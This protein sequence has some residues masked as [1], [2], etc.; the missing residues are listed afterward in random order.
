M[1]PQLVKL[2]GGMIEAGKAYIG[3][4]KLFVSGIRDLS[5]HCQKDQMISVSPPRPHPGT[6]ILD[7]PGFGNISS[8]CGSSLNIPGCCESSRSL[9]RQSPGSGGPAVIGLV[10]ISQQL[11]DAKERLCLQEFL[12]KCGES[13]QE[14]SNYHSV[15][16]N[17]RTAPWFF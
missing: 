7:F 8:F 9:T 5:Q 10:G 12:E 11:F 4:S 15:S 16:A 14:I 17:S 6:L 2:C 1:S 3:T 13:L